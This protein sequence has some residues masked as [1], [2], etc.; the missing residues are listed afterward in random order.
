MEAYT[1]S[2]GQWRQVHTQVAMNLS[3]VPNIDAHNFGDYPPGAFRPRV[4]FYSTVTLL[5]R[6]RDL[7]TS[8][9]R[10]TAM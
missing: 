6:L 4:R 5:A 3:D 7:S 1:I 8:Q 9:A 2:S 10:S